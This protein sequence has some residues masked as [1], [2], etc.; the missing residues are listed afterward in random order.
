MTYYRALKVHKVIANLE[1]Y[2]DKV[3]ERD[4]IT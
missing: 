2:A 3:D 4:V 1:V